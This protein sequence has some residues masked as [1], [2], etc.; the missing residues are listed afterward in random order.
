MQALAHLPAQGAPRY[1]LEVDP[2]TPLEAGDRLVTCGEP[3][4]VAALMEAAGEAEP[5]HLRWAGWLSRYGRAAWR[6][7]PGRSARADLH[8]RPAAVLGG[9]TLL[10][11][12]T[13]PSH[14][15]LGEALLRTV[16]VMATYGE[17][18]E[19]DLGIRNG[20]DSTSASCASRGRR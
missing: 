8:A 11:Y 12:G 16:G 13:A 9:S 18:H 14:L 19:A 20:C 15:S 2:E 3:A 5:P 6:R 4:A 1:L 7:R 10:L 17:F